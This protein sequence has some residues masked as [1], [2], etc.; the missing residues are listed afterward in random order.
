VVTGGLAGPLVALVGS[1]LLGAATS[2]IMYSATHSE[3]NFSWTSW[4]NEIGIGAA[5]GAITG[6]GSGIALKAGMVARGVFAT[7]HLGGRIA[8]IGLWS[9]RIAQG[10]VAGAV[11]A[12]GNALSSYIG[13]GIR[14]EIEGNGKTWG[15]GWRAAV[16]RGAIM[17]AVS[18]VAGSA[19]QNVGKPLIQGVVSSRN[20]GRADFL[21]GLAMGTAAG[22]IVGFSAMGSQR[23]GDQGGGP[24]Q[25]TQPPKA[26]APLQFTPRMPVVS[27]WSAW[28]P[29]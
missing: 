28:S 9:G 10:I 4:G 1:T 8:T 21:W 24:H 27:R 19:F 18:G 22:S 26:Q 11:A 17:G 2:A 15:M 25:P 16:E 6:V 13:N 7:G 29:A 20:L 3:D 12:G 14:N 23:G 5:T